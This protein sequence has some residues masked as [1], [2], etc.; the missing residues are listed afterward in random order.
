MILGGAVALAAQ[1]PAAVDASR[2]HDLLV[3]I[4]SADRIRG[5]RGGDG[6]GTDRAVGRAGAGRER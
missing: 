2:V 5:A 1:A 3:L 4:E 6:A